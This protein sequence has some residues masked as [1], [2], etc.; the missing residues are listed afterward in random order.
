LGLLLL[1]I[2]DLSY[3]QMQFLSADDPAGRDRHWM[4]LCIRL[5]ERAQAA[6]EVPV[7][8]VV[9]Q[10]DRLVSLGFNQREASQDP[11][12]HAELFAIRAAAT[13]LGSWRLSGCTLYV[14]LEPCAMCAGAMVLGRISRCVYGC[15]DPKGGF[16]GSLGDLSRWPGL[17]HRFEVQGGVE[18][19]R[20]S[21]QLKSF[22]KNLRSK[23]IKGPS[24][25]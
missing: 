2:F 23:R 24:T 13:S 6:G 18:A 14:T 1:V 4:D 16:L 7:G 10:G 5:A 8:A 9:V 11:C 25:P 15:A 20:C 19:D 21:A 22:F 3:S 17:N 12:G